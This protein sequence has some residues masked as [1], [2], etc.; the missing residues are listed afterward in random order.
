[1]S[2]VPSSTQI[3]PSGR[4]FELD[5][6]RGFAIL[7]VIVRH[8]V[9]G[10]EHTQ[11]GFFFH[12]LLLA[13]SIGWSGVDLFFVLS[14][15][16]IGG[17][18]LDAR[19]SSDYFRIF[20]LRRVFRIFP[21][22]YLWILPY[23][24][25]VGGALWLFPGR[26]FVNSRDLVQIPVQVF[27]LRDFLMAGMPPLAFQ[28]LSVTWSLAVEEQFY[29]VAPL[30]VRFLKGKQLLIVL[31]S[32]VAL[33]P[34]LRF[35]LFQHGYAPQAYYSMPCRADCLACG[36]LIA[37]AW[38]QPSWRLYLVSHPHVLR[39]ALIVFLVGLGVLT[40]WLLHPMGVVTIT[41]ALSWIALLWSTLLLYL[42]SHPTSRLAA[43]ARWPPLR[44]LGKISYCV[45]LVHDAFNYFVHRMLLHAGPQIYNLQGVFATLLA[46][47]LT[48]S[49][50]S[51]SWHYLEQPLLRR[52]HRYSFTTSPAIQGP[53]AAIANN[54]LS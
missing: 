44:Y 17:I 31:T 10:A 47:L 21:I 32:I 34:L 22:Y 53:S 30:L 46:L 45:Y 16:L 42:L 18:L 5:G 24:L 25:Y 41:L 27:F 48:I 8:Y 14:G 2:A 52:S 37:I 20:Y 40:W 35:V 11:L 50:A 7:I 4:I 38:R 54:D 12:H 19:A 33:T 3:N 23:A 15:F 26:Y 28:W 51:I 43:I 39:R 6:L 9:G 36:I 29:L 13:T 1:L 49:V